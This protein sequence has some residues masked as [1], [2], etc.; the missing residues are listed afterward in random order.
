MDMMF[1]II[2]TIPY[3]RNNYIKY[4]SQGCVALAFIVELGLIDGYF[5]S[6]I[7]TTLDLVV[8]IAYFVTI[9]MAFYFS[10]YEIKNSDTTS[11]TMNIFDAPHS[12]YWHQ[13]SLTSVSKII[14]I[15]RA[16]S[17][18]NFRYRGEVNAIPL[19][20]KLYDYIYCGISVQKQDRTLVCRSLYTTV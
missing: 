5:V 9:W 8:S 6:K 4:Y 11:L 16:Q 15:I 12:Y 13:I 3:L 14:S 20:M 7:L 2:I 10:V 18:K 1:I 19:L 17:C